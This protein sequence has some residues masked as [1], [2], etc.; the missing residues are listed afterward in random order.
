MTVR[1]CEMAF[2]D[3][4]HY[5][6]FYAYVKLKEQE[7]RNIVWICECVM[8]GLASETTKLLPCFS[9]SSWWRMGGGT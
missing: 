8:Q 4:F 7:T 2:E 5:G 1:L 3:Q 9:K 6:I